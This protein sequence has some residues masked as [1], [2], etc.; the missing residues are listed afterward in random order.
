MV[1]E[2]QGHAHMQWTGCRDDDEVGSSNDTADLAD[3]AEEEFTRMHR[4][5]S[6]Y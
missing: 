2:R 3:Q 4:T 6:W 1:D 5:L